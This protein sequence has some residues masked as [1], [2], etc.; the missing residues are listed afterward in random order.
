MQHNSPLASYLPAQL[1][2][3]LHDLSHHVTWSSRRWLYLREVEEA[4]G[5]GRWRR[6]V[7]EAGGGYTL[8]ESLCGAV[9]LKMRQ[10]FCTVS[11]PACLRSFPLCQSPFS[12]GKEIFWSRS[13]Y[14]WAALLAGFC[15]A[16]TVR[17]LSLSLRVHLRRKRPSG[18][19][20]FARYTCN[21]S[22]RALANGRR[23]ERGGAKQKSA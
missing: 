16:M 5:R 11:Y 8:G 13:P 1:P 6:Q 20:I 19:L 14:S 22:V 7:E 4:G 10:A 17:S 9:M 2:H 21:I 15:G 3:N 18:V 12:V 23:E